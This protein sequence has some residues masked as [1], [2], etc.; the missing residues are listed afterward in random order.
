MVLDVLGTNGD[1]ADYWTGYVLLDRPKWEARQCCK[2][3]DL[4]RV[5]RIYWLRGRKQ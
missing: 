1:L 3:A 5:F 4:I 2:H